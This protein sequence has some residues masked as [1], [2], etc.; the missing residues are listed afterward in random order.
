MAGSLR[1]NVKLGP[2]GIDQGEIHIYV[3]IAGLRQHLTS[4]LRIRARGGEMVC[5]LQ[6]GLQV[7]ALGHSGVFSGASHRV[8]NTGCDVADRRTVKTQG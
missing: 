6:D 2:D 5:Y 4:S 7:W 3:C 8:I 1:V